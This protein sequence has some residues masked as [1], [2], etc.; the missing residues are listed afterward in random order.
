[1][2]TPGLSSLRDESKIVLLTD[3]RQP[4]KPILDKE[5]LNKHNPDIS[6]PSSEDIATVRLNKK[7]RNKV[8]HW[9]K[10]NND[11][12]FESE[13]EFEDL[14]VIDHEKDIV[15]LLKAKYAPYLVGED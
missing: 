14:N 8:I 1:M 3:G 6:K 13:D 12:L 2:Q 11:C 15:T 4:P 9:M 7:I 10:L 5:K